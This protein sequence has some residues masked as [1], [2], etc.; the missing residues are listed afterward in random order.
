M[1]RFTA[2]RLIVVNYG[3]KTRSKIPL[4]YYQWYSSVNGKL[5]DSAPIPN[6]IGVESGIRKEHGLNKV[7]QMDKH[8]NSVLRKVMKKID[9]FKKKL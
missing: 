7:Q 9:E 3:E 1:S 5:F 8:Y 4:K 6:P 2:D